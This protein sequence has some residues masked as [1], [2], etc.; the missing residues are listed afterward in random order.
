[1][2]NLLEYLLNHSLN[3]KDLVPSLAN[4]KEDKQLTFNA[5]AALITIVGKQRDEIKALQKLSISSQSIEK[6]LGNIVE[7]LHEQVGDLK[8][9]VAR[10]R[11]EISSLR[12]SM[13]NIGGNVY[14]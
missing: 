9:T 13:W 6:K 3:N 12:S 7:L 10:Q 8:E 1:M 14:E 5:I 2:N 11:S 4:D